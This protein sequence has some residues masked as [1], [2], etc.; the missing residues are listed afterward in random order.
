VENYTD[1]TLAYTGGTVGVLY[2]EIPT[3]ASGGFDTSVDLGPCTSPYS[4]SV[5]YAGD[6]THDPADSSTRFFMDEK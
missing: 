2:R 5:H 3:S 1:A 6:S 4:V